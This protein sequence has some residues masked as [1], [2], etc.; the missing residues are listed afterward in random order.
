MSDKEQ[1]KA[2]E[3]V[4]DQERDLAQNAL[5]EFKKNNYVACLQNISKLDSRT[6]DL[7]VIHNKAVVE[8]YKSDFKK[9]EQFQKNLTAVCNQVI[10]INLKSTLKFNFI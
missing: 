10:Y 8:Y 2:P 3:I 1:E 7:K 4:T 6:N 5:A 9:T